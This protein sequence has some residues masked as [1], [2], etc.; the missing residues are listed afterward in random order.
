VKAYLG[1]GNVE[2]LREKFRGV[3]RKVEAAA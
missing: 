2:H 1:S 3:A